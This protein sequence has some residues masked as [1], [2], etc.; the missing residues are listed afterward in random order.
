MGVEKEGTKNGGSFFHLFDWTSKSRKKLFASKSDLPGTYTSCN[1][2][3]IVHFILSFSIA[4]F[5][6]IISQNR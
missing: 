5:C 6:F 4:K 2:V 3:F 1:S